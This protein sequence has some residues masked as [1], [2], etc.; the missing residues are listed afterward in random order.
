MRLKGL[1]F[2]FLISTSAP[3]WA[4]RVI[5]TTVPDASVVGKGRLTYMLWDVYD[6]TLYAPQGQWKAEKPFALSIHY[7]HSINSDDLTER[8]IEEM[9]KQ[10]FDDDARL[11]DW[12]KQMQIIFPDVRKGT[13][14]SG[15]YLPGVETR[16]YEGERLIGSITD[17]EFGRRFFAIWLDEKTSE[18]D[19]RRK[20]LGML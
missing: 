1:L 7:L 16:F 13:V 11:A 3:A 2:L 4:N 20:L 19:L 18:P 12:R 17:D 9:R 15:V 6:A 5:E 10:G 8:S 14:I